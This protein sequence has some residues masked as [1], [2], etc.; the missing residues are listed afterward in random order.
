MYQ[1]YLPLCFH[2]ITRNLQPLCTILQVLENI[3]LK[4]I[5]EI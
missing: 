2:N 4:R 1:K 5:Y 3:L